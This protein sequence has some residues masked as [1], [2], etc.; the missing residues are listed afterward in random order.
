MQVIVVYSQTKFKNSWHCHGSNYNIIAAVIVLDLE[1]EVSQIFANL[2]FILCFNIFHLYFCFSDK[3]VVE[4]VVDFI[5]DVVP[6]VKA[7]LYNNI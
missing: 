4:S 1:R 5:S 2:R 6:Q 3:T 7:I